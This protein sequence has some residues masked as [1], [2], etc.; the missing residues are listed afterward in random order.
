MK[1][2]H[3]RL[4][5]VFFVLAGFILPPASLSASAPY[6]QG[7]VIRMI[8]GSEPGGNYDRMARLLA[9]H[10]PKY[11]PGKPTIIIE[12]MP[13][14]GSLIAAN[15]V[16]S[17]AAADGLTIGGAFHR[18]EAGVR[19]VAGVGDRRL[20]GAFHVSVASDD[21]GHRVA[22][23]HRR[24]GRAAVRG[25]A[26]RRHGVTC[27]LGWGHALF[28]GDPRAARGRH[29]DPHLLHHGL[30]LGRNRRHRRSEIHLGGNLPQTRLALSG[31]GRGGRREQRNE[32]E[33][34]QRYFHFGCSTGAGQ[35]G[36]AAC[37][38]KGSGSASISAPPL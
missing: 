13:G 23:H 31:V 11:I 6:Y 17:K 30:L 35:S 19:G 8:S 25:I 24:R 34:A 32:N 9:R 18:E 26:R 12:N 15:H 21:G 14:A 27:G 22:T 20:A 33:N 36:H 7:K 3:L 38:P 16:Y 28:G 4:L 2:K 10:L 29:L 37:E 1:R 5:V